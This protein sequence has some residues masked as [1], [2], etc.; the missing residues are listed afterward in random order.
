MRREGQEFGNPRRR[1]RA[2]FSIGNVEHSLVVTDPVAER[3]FFGREDGDYPLVET[4]LS[5]SLGEAHTDGNCYKLVAA[6]ISKEA[7]RER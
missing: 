7:L 4:Y 5:V 6:V 1:V 2:Q 3:V